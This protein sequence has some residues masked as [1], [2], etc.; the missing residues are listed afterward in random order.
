MVRQ[1]FICVYFLILCGATICDIP[2]YF[3]AI[4]IEGILIYLKK[5]YFYH[6]S[7]FINFLWV[8]L[9]STEKKIIFIQKSKKQGW[10]NLEDKNKLTVIF[11][12]SQ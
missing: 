4:V 2:E 10:F 8:C 6:Y 1:I 7:V 5:N 3:D 9:K 12:F 11:L